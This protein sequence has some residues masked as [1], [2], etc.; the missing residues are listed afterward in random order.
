MSDAAGDASPASFAQLRTSTLPAGKRRQ[1][2]GWRESSI[3]TRGLLHARAK[4]IAETL[5]AVYLTTMLEWLM[6]EDAPQRWLADAMR[7]RLRLV[8]EDAA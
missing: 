7:A 1:H 5:F 6:R 4:L 2:P 8:L 3:S